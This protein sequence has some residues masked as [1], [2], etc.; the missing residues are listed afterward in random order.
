MINFIK[1]A[2]RGEVENQTTL[3]LKFILLEFLL[4]AICGIITP[5]EM[6]YKHITYSTEVYLHLYKQIFSLT[7]PIY[8]FMVVAIIRSTK[9]IAY[10]DEGKI[11]SESFFNLSKAFAGIF[12]LI[13]SYLANSISVGGVR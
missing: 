5:L 12:I 2:W 10:T 6:R 1:K 8:I 7:L 4:F 13:T 9:K 3:I 11:T